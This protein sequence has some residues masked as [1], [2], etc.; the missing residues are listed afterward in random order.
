M[1]IKDI[2]NREIVNLTNCDQEP[3]HIP[4]SI[5]P[6]G[7]LLGLKNDLTV[8]FCSAN[9]ESFLHLK[10]EQILTRHIITVFNDATSKAIINYIDNI[11]KNNSPLLIEF[12][13]KKFYA[14]I[15]KSDET[16]I[17]E[18]E[19]VITNAP[20]ASIVY[21]QTFQF[22]KYMEQAQ[23]LQQLCARIA[24]EV[25]GLTGYDRVMI[26]RFDKFYNGEIYAESKR[27]D[28]EPFLGL[29]YPHTDIPVQA[30]Q[31]YIINLLRLIVDVNYQSVPLLTID[32]TPDKNLDLSLSTLRSV[33]PIHVQYLQNMG[34]GA[35]LTISLL[36]KGRLW[37]LIACHH[38]SAKYIDHY[39]RINAQLQAH[40]L[41]S[42]IDVR[43]M[44]EEYVVAG[45][46]NDSLENLLNHVFVPGRSSLETIIK[47]PQ[48]TA[49]CNAAGACI[50]F[51]DVIYKTGLTPSDDAIRNVAEW[52]CSKHS[53]YVYST[54]K[55]VDEFAEAK[56]CAAAAGII[57]CSLSSAN[58]SCIIWF[59][60]ESLEEV[61][62]AGE[63]EKAIIK[64]EKGLHPRKSFETWKQVVKCQAREWMK[65]ELTAATNFAYAL[66]KH[67]TLLLL[68]EEEMRQRLLSEE[69]KASNAEL[70]NIN[71]LSTHDL[72]EPLRKIQMFSSKL[73]QTEENL[74]SNVN[75]TLQKLSNSA[76][77]MQQ[78]IQDLTN[79]SKIRKTNEG[80]AL[81]QLNDLLQEVCD[82]FTD[83]I[84]EKNVQLTIAKNLPEVTGIPVL[85]QELFVNLLRNSVKFSKPDETAV[86]NIT[87]AKD[88]LAFETDA[89]PKT[90]NIVTVKD[91]GIGFDNK[92]ADDIFKIFS[93]LNNASSFEGS[94]IGLALCKK[95]MQIH[96]GHITAEGQP[97]KGASFRL[98]FPAEISEG[99]SL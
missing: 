94:G 87:T 79:Y 31:L 85:I 88:V 64:D 13:D 10:P 68:T 15:H 81:I 14:V 33:S 70:E 34:V 48:L 40:F 2:V 39:T 92:F 72:K 75:S 17:A 90:Y 42:Q 80:F 95:I 1:K 49:L 32:D 38:Y 56:D 58:T 67:I 36:N 30:R 66:Q 9:V 96:H 4:G 63:P 73:M 78:L 82:V 98:Y 65:P 23:T 97:G 71:W 76:K 37:G 7:F 3:I 77:R 12:D 54:S 25:R 19:P 93:R 24:D 20:K 16:W 22:V 84:Q 51:N 55:L 28:L 91:T 21:D 18:F 47:H 83:D 89:S 74:P 50:L 60:P 44:A 35:T 5:Q 46:V 53:L 27:D 26:Y 86:I 41:T 11:D 61:H 45:K 99:E 52:G 59:N 6:H 62:W 8:E 43:Q 69:L 29:H 57:F